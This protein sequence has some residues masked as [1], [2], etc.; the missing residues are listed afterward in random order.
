MKVICPICGS[1]MVLFGFDVSFR[2]GHCH[3]YFCYACSI[4]LTI[5]QI[6]EIKQIVGVEKKK[7]YIK[8]KHG[9]GWDVYV[10]IKKVKS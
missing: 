4:Q 3:S 8:S 2:Y 6:L 10:K 5:P 1:Y 9:S 7:Q